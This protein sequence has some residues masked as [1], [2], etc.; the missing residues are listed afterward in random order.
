MLHPRFKVMLRET[1]NSFLKK[2]NQVKSSTERERGE[3]NEENVFERV[4]TKSKVG[5]NESGKRARK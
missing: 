1:K 5:L 4:D 2:C 3:R